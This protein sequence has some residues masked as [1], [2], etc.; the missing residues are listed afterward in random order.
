MQHLFFRLLGLIDAHLV[1]QIQFLKAQNEILRSCLG[2]EVHTRPEERRR[3]L[4]FG[5]LLGDAL[6]DLISFY[7]MPAAKTLERLAQASPPD[8][9]PEEVP[10]L[11]EEL[12]ALGRVVRKSF[13]ER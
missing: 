7:R 13:R 9:K 11:R 5:L 10:R 6:K 2:K 3:L 12:V 8:P 4:K 1:R